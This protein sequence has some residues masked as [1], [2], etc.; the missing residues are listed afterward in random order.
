VRT[1]TESIE[2][3]IKLAEVNA[4]ATLGRPN[5]DV[6]CVEAD[7]KAIVALVKYNM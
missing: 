1:V 6:D 2:V 3:K 4:S 7:A 5:Y